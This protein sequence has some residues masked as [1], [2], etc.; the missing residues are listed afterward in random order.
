MGT[1]LMYRIAGGEAGM[2]HFMAQF[3][4]ALKWPW[5]QA[6]GRPRADRRAARHASSTDRCSRP[7]TPTIRELEVLRD[8]C[9]IAVMQGLRTVGYG[10]GEV[11]DALRAP[12]V[13]PQSAAPTPTST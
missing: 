4:P 3:G 10:A 8:D 9:L 1:F 5:T 13:R 2:R 12:A 6:D 7:A 11:L